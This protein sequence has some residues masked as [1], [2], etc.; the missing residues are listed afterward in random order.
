MVIDGL[1]VK[2]GRCEHEWLRRTGR[3]KQCPKCRS[4][5]WDQPRVRGEGKVADE[6][7]AQKKIA[8]SLAGAGPREVGVPLACPPMGKSELALDLVAQQIAGE[9]LDNLRDGG[10]RLEEKEKVAAE[11]VVAPVAR[12]PE[13][14]ASLR[15]IAAGN[16]SKLN[17]FAQD[18]DSEPVEVDLC[19][20]KSYNEID[21][22]NYICG[23]E[24]HGPKVKHG[25]WIKI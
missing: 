6:V 3:P 2:C 13:L 7:G 22:E 23:L 15:E 11:S 17:N 1:T 12:T 20:F 19:G 24:K 5:Y 9:M 21:G 14:M 16:T 25:E 4:P 10:R 18:Y 8:E